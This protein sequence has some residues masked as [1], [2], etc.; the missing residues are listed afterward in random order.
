MQQIAITLGLSCLTLCSATFAYL[1]Y[2]KLNQLKPQYCELSNVF[3][4]VIDAQRNCDDVDNSYRAL[5]ADYKRDKAILAERENIISQYNIGVG[6]TDAI[7][8]RTLD[9]SSDL[10]KLNVMLES[11]KNQANELVKS[12]RA[13]VCFMEGQDSMAV[14]G[15][16]AKA[17][18]LINREIKLRLRCFDNEVNAAI[19]LADWNN[20][21][22]LVDRLKRS[23]DEIN[24][25]GVMIK[26]KLK[27]E[28]LHLKISELKLSYE[29]AS[30]AEELKEQERE[31]KR[32]AT[33]AQREEAKIKRA[34][35]SAKLARERMEKLIQKELAKLDSMSAAQREQLAQ[36]QQEL[37]V[38]LQREKR[39]VS[40]AQIT[41]AGY[42]YII[43]N[44]PS[45]GKHVVKIGMTRRVDPNDRVRELG[46][47][48]V[49]DL[50]QT[51]AFFYSEDAPALE[52]AL[53]KQF[54]E[55]RVNLVNKRK[56]FFM[57]TPEEAITAVEQS[58]LVTQRT[59]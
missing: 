16:K 55:K 9:S 21:N 56:E 50:F 32:L 8:Y 18:A 19:S 40:M 6:T 58:G 1:R 10:V 13:C 54:H 35:E 48:S 36:H 23:F 28:Y 42:V 46:D 39:A 3:Q 31:D 38:L 7:A 51:H 45:F 52:S 57:V 24:Q 17:K 12:K 27:P 5:Q 41:R 4:P 26:V 15:S 53:H 59:F 20:I 33:E 11:V 22:R 34:A 37:E 2:Q 47:A 49:P 44:E 30:L 29:I 14:N 43:S 25:R